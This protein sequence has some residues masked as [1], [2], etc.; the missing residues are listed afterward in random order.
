MNLNKG[1]I[2]NGYWYFDEYEDDWVYVSSAEE[3]AA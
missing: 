2:M 3:L 1:G